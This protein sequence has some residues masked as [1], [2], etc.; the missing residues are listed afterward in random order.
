MTDVLTI[1]GI[2]VLGAFLSL[3][4]RRLNR[5]SA[6][7]CAIAGG[8]LAL[9]FALNQLNGALAAL[10]S[11]AADAGMT[12]ETLQ[13]LLRILSTALIIELAAQLCRDTGEDG[14]AQKALLAG[15]WILLS[16]AVPQLIQIGD[17]LLSLLPKG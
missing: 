1:T 4:L 2:A 8:L 9:L 14:L 10:K 15:Q 12:G 3:L 5:E 6:I 16:M 7:L 13:T 11:W 17:R